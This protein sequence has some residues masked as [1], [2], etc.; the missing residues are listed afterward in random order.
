MANDVVLTEVLS[1]EIIEKA[2]NAGDVV[3]FRL[4][5]VPGP[6]WKNWQ[7]T[8]LQKWVRML[9]T[10]ILGCDWECCQYVIPMFAPE[11][12][13]TEQMFAAVKKAYDDSMAEGEM[14]GVIELPWPSA[15]G[16]KRK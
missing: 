3:V 9:L 11:G 12:M 2:R 8:A 7:R 1:K 6:Q 10:E 5:V 4:P 13:T 14:P 16:L 15:V